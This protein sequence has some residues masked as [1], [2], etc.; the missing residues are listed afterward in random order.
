MSIEHFRRTGRTTRMM[1]YAADKASRGERVCVL[2][3]EDGQANYWREW[4]HAHV[5]TTNV[6]V[7]LLGDWI[8]AG[9]VNLRN[10]QWVRPGRAAVEELIIDHHAVE[11]HFSG[12]I[13]HALRFTDQVRED[14][15]IIPDKPVMEPIRRVGGRRMNLREQE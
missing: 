4:L 9:H 11:A 7:G 14:P 8:S 2:F 3:Q 13:W 5:G 15:M 1:L 6:Q 12:V 10:L